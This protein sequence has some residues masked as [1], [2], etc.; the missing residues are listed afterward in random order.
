MFT[1]A[2]REAFLLLGRFALAEVQGTADPIH[3]GGHIKLDGVAVRLSD[4]LDRIPVSPGTVFLRKSIAYGSQLAFDPDAWVFELANA[5]LG[6]TV[7]KRPGML[8]HCRSVIHRFFVQ[9]LGAALPHNGR[10]D[11]VATAGNGAAWGYAAQCMV[12]NRLLSSGDRVVVAGDRLSDGLKLPNLGVFG[13]QT[14]HIR[15]EPSDGA[16]PAAEIAKLA[17]P[18]IKALFVIS[19][20][21]RARA[22]C[23]EQLAGIVRGDRP[24]LLVLADESYTALG[25]GTRSFAAVLPGSVLTTYSFSAHFGAAG[26]Q[27]GIVALHTANA[28][29]LAIAELPQRIRRRLARRYAES[30]PDWAPAPF[31]DRVAAESGSLALPGVGG[32]SMP[33]QAQATLFAL[34]GL[35]GRDR[36]CVAQ[37]ATFAARRN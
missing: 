9:C 35:V 8:P 18:E 12:V 24:D 2:P 37:P 31:I 33:Q 28:F 6:E 11:I 10:F 25:D 3:D 4:Y 20:A 36:Q 21:G 5:V 15:P 1:S 23:T 19:P 30:G 26:W 7:P 34:V 27:L 22:A 16:F 17:D 32:L 13:L 29:D 14:L